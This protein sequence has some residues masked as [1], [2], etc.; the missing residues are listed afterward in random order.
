MKELLSVVILFG[1]ITAQAQ[2]MTPNKITKLSHD[3][4]SGITELQMAGTQPGKVY[5]IYRSSKPF[6]LDNLFFAQ[7]VAA[8][9]P[10]TQ[11]VVSIKVNGSGRYYYLMTEARESGYETIIIND[12]TTYGPLDE[13]DKTAP[14]PIHFKLNCDLLRVILSWSHTS[15]QNIDDIREYRIYRKEDGKQYE[16]VA[17][18][19]LNYDLKDYVWIDKLNKKNETYSYCI[20]AVDASGNESQKEAWKKT[21]SLPD[22]TISN[23]TTIAHNKDFSISRA[24]PVAK[25]K[26]ELGITIRNQGASTADN[27]ETVIYV[28]DNNG[29]KKTLSNGRISIP[30]GGRHVIKTSWIPPAE[31]KYCLEVGI[32]P[33]RITKEL[34]YTNNKAE[35]EIY[36]VKKDI[37]FLWYQ[38][39]AD[40]TYANLSSGNNVAEWERRGG[41]ACAIS[42]RIKNNPDAYIYYVK[43]GYKAMQLDEIGGNYHDIDGI[44]TAIKKCKIK[45]PEFKIIVWHIG[46]KI[47]P[48]VIKL[49]KEKKIDLLV[50]EI[51]IPVGNKLTRL[52]KA[53]EVINENKIAIN[54]LIGI[55]YG[56]AY[57]NNQ[58]SQQ[59]IKHIEQQLKLIRLKSPMIPGVA[60]YAGKSSPVVRKKADELCRK[61]FLKI[62]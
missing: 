62:K 18:K 9:V 32:N 24:Y 44:L 25:Q 40:L 58:S 26:V 39:A 8:R 16:R 17:N 47:L 6:T 12:S 23:A 49:L 36:V 15:L 42:G 50:L 2:K 35:V 7:R 48:S 34:N 29:V 61:Y 54:T 31:G 45:Y 3:H 11:K 20:T 19:K 4:N 53:L 27:V 33:N 46:Y 10:W 43:N 30:A 56:K 57:A 14:K 5:N 52:E 37:Y 51:Y 41:F 38:N 60:F 28:S 13:T 22:L 1:V 55:A 59:Q 21:G